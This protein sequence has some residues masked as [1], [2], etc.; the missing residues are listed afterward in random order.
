MKIRNHRALARRDFQKALARHLGNA[1]VDYRT[2]DLHPLGKFALR[3][4]LL[5]Y[6]ELA[7]ENHG[8]QF[9]HEQLLERR[10]GQFFEH[11]FPPLCLLFAWYLVAPEITP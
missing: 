6:G 8:F 7:R 3:R 4:E 9:L 1:I 10:R 5:A 2:A 11:C